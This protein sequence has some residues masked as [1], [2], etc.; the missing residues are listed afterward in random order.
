M[1][2][3]LQKYLADA[4][5]CS[6]RRGEVYIQEGRV[7]VNGVVVSRPGIRIDPNEDTI[8]LDG[9]RVTGKT[10][11]V[12]IMLN[13]PKGVI[14]SCSHRGEKIVLDLVDVDAR[15]F[16]VGRLDRDSTGLLI[17]TNDGRL[18]Q[19]LT[20]PSFDHEKEYEVETAAPV[21]NADLDRLSRGVVVDGRKTRAAAV[22]RMAGNRFDIVLQEGRKRQIRRMVEK[23]GNRV[24]A[25]HRVR[26]ATLRLGNLRMSHWRHLTEKEKKDLMDCCF[27]KGKQPLS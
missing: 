2:I 18:H 8:E 5:V 14:S 16:P 1:K 17:M 9:R 27:P 13:K 26:I 20:H 19:R 3:R 21:S 15:I 4:G 22:T 10:S 11:F 6:R 23:I 7:R 24:T 12:Y 25:L